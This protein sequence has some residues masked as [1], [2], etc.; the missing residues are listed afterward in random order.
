[1]AQRERGAALAP[2]SAVSSRCAVRDAHEREL[3]GHEERR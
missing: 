2:S 1:M 3:G